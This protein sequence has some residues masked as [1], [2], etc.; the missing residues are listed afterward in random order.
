MQLLSTAPLPPEDQLALDEALLLRADEFDR[1][2]DGET[3]WLRLWS[4]QQPVVVL[5]RSSKIA[6]EVD[7]QAC[8]EA[9]VPVLRRCSGGAAIV[10]GPGCWMYSLVLSLDRRPELR[11]IDAAHRFVM[12][13]LLAAV[14]RQLPTARFEGT[15]DLTWNGRKF[16]GNSLRIARHHL[17]YHGTVLHDA[18]LGL[19]ARC[20]DHAPRQPE[21][22]RGRSHREFIVNAPLSPNPLNADLADA[23]QVESQVTGLT[24]ELRD[25]IERLKAERYARAEWHHRH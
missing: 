14:G 19:I 22:R 17:L 15:C 11:K 8:R 6:R 13:R 24:P 23:V 16:S 21:Y 9:G 25:S 3:E 10:G 12:N 5:G 7:L 18:D 20:L 4:F 2:R 1:E